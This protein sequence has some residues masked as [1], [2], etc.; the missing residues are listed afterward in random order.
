LSN[1]QTA[2]AI[3]RV[4]YAELEACG[5]AINHQDNKAALEQLSEAT[6]KLKRIASGL[7]AQFS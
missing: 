4:I 7:V 6:V 3:R 2:V 5:T 1:A